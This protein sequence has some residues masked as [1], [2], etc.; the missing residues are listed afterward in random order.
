MTKTLEKA[1]EAIKSLPE[2]RQ[3]EV[4]QWLH[5]FVA[6]EN[7]TAQ[8]TPDQNAEVHRRV[9]EQPERPVSETEATAFFKKLA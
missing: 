3:D 7:S 6:Q 9:H 2:H 5:D 8:L 1:I 4:G